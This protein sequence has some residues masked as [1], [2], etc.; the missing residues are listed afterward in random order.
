MVASERIHNTTLIDFSSECFLLYIF[1]ASKV[2]VSGTYSS[3]GDSSTK[4]FKLISVIPFLPNRN[5][6]DS[7]IPLVKR[8]LTNVN[9][10]IVVITFFFFV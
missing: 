5:D 1:P 8:A 9:I 7:T 2:S 10:L 6:D 4:S 3:Q